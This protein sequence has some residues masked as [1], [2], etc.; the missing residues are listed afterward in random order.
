M[1]PSK[2]VDDQERNSCRLNVV[3]EPL[4]ANVNHVPAFCLVNLLSSL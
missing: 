2:R 1:S 4:L 3:N